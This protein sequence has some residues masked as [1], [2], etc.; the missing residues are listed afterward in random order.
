MHIE[1]VTKHLVSEHMH[2]VILTDLT[3]S[4]YNLGTE[5]AEDN[6]QRLHPDSIAKACSVISFFSLIS[7]A[8]FTVVLLPR[9]SGQLCLDLGA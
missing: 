3:K 7:H 1:F 6:N 5:W 9:Q 8:Y 4:S 2:L